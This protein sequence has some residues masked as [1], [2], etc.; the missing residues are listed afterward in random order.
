MREDFDKVLVERPRMGHKNKYRH[1]RNKKINKRQLEVIS[2]E[3][4]RTPHVRNWGGK[5]L[6]EN[7]SPLKHYLY[8]K[9][10]Q[11]WDDVYSDIR[12]MMGKNPNAVKGHILQ[13]IFQYVEKNTY[14]KEGKRYRN[15]GYSWR[16]N[17]YELPNEDLYID[18]DGYLRKYKRKVVKQLTR[19]Q[20]QEV[21]RMKTERL[22]HDGTLA[23][24]INGIWF[25]IEFAPIE[26]RHIHIFKYD[27]VDYLTKQTVSKVKETVT[28]NDVLGVRG[29]PQKFEETY[30]KRVY[31][32]S[33]K[34]MNSQSLK[35]NGLAND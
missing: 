35:R 8:S 7:L 14:E 34:A 11:R 26:S 5:R 23:R 22:L 29:S 24:K 21:E 4:M 17:P 12:K 16:S 20:Q 13:H 18:D 32:R 28:A 25:V 31:A 2:H 10:G 9:V 3:G 19:K 27:T 1:V 15:T 6:N 30:G 33:K